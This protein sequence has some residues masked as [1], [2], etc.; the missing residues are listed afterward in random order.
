LPVMFEQLDADPNSIAIQ[1][2]LVQDAGEDQV[3]EWVEKTLAAMPEKVAEYRRGKKGIIGLFVG[4]VKRISGG[5]A[6]P[7]ITT[8]LL[9]RYLN[10]N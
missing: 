3:N 6:D 10:K 1:N 2:N 4:E 9:N 5:K 7:R 8:E